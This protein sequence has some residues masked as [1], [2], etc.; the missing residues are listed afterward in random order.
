MLYIN[1]LLKSLLVGYFTGF[2]VSIPLGPSGIESVNRSISKGFFEG[3]KVSL[4]AVAADLTY[5]LI[6][7]LGL[8]NFLNKNKSFESLFWILSG[9]ILIIFNHFSQ[10]S[11]STTTFN[12]AKLGGFFSGFLITFL[13]P[14]TPSLWLAVSGTIMNVWRLKGVLF[15]TVSFISMILGSISW[16]IVLNLLATK[17]VRFFKQNVAK[18]T[19]SIL[20]YVLL[21]LGILFICYGIIKF[22][23]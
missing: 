15:F 7:N 8:F 9:I 3:L 14:M 18:K 5:L 10:K 12:N 1:T 16:F 11:K 21:F 2:T 13:N 22:I 20:N 23:S 17:G 19:S 4:G 6:I